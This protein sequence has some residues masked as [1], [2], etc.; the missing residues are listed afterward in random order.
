LVLGWGVFNRR[1]GDFCTGVDKSIADEWDRLAARIGALPEPA[2]AVIAA[3]AAWRLMREHLELPEHL[4]MD[5][6]VT[7]ANVVSMLWEDVASS[8]E[9][10]KR[11]LDTKIQEYYSGPYC[12]EL[13]EDALPGAE[14]DAAAAAIY[15][16]EAYCTGNAKHAVCAAMQLLTDAEARA[17]QI[18]PASGEHETARESDARIFRFQQIELSRLNR[19]VSL[20]EMEGLPRAMSLI[21]QIFGER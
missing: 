16:A 15:A 21:R 14:E 17:N 18:T 8:S 9:H 1:Y 7:W 6:T 12:H 3:G 5:F 19:I 4:R 13:A 20:L 2:R 11:V 10:V